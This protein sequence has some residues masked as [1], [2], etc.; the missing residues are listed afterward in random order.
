MTYLFFSPFSLFS[1]LIRPSYYTLDGATRHYES[2]NSS[3]Y[4][5]LSRVVHV[6]VCVLCWY[7]LVASEFLECR[8]HWEIVWDVVWVLDHSAHSPFLNPVIRTLSYLLT[9]L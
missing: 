4:I 1:V 2:C 3:F 5:I 8:D 7:L 6:Y 9:R